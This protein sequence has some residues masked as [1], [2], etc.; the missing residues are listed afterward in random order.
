MGW[1]ELIWG[2]PKL[3]KFG[4]VTQ[5]AHTLLNV[6][7]NQQ[8][9]SIIFSGP[10][11]KD[12]LTEGEYTKQF[13]LDRINELREFPSLEKLISQLSPLEYDVFVKRMQELVVG[14]VINN[15]LEEVAR[16]AKFFNEEH[17]VDTVFQISAASHA[18]RCLQNQLIA[19]RDGIIPM[20][21]PWYMVAS[22]ISFAG[23]KIEDVVILEPPHRGDDPM[24]GYA[25]TLANVIKPYFSLG[26]EQKQRLI[27]EIQ[28]ITK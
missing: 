16:G 6:P 13:L 11:T 12:K 15:T 3:E 10:S 22:D 25:P 5:F 20:H 14:P 21:Q 4:T 27:M 7:A 9:S 23:T 26:V 28:D 8:V 17:P 2:N 19:R 1:D 24:V 18:P